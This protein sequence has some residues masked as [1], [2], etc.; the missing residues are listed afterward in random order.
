MSF[1][2]L[3]QG[4]VPSKVET[5]TP[6]PAPMSVVKNLRTS[7][8]TS[9][10]QLL[11]SGPGPTPRMARATTPGFRETGYTLI[12][13]ANDAP[14]KTS[15]RSRKKSSR[16]SRKVPYQKA[17]TTS[18]DPPSSAKGEGLHFWEK[19][20]YVNAVLE[21]YKPDHKV[22]LQTGIDDICDLLMAPDRRFVTVIHQAIAKEVNRLR[23]ERGLGKREVKQ[24]S[25]AWSATVKRQIQMV[26]RE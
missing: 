15:S 14:P 18:S 3:F 7:H 25:D 26:F 10:R 1:D 20:V 6:L 23:A 5:V 22:S 21:S 16:G 11:S 9:M 17:P 24:L 13:E 8:E 2:S 19:E 4:S 12:E